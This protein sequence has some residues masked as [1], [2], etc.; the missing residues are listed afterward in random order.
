MRRVKDAPTSSIQNSYLSRNFARPAPPTSPALDTYSVL[1]H[2]L[3]RILAK[4]LFRSISSLPHILLP[5]HHRHYHLKAEIKLPAILPPRNHPHTFKCKFQDPYH[6]QLFRNSL[7]QQ[8][9]I[10]FPAHLPMIHLSTF[11]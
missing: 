10:L 5:W 7:L 4:S 3:C 6:Q 11:T 1:D 8:F 9:S 2:V